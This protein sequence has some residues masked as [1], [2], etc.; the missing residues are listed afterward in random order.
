MKNFSVL[1][2]QLILTYYFIR[3]ETIFAEFKHS[4]IP[5]PGWTLPPQ[6]YK[7]FI[8]FEKLGCLTNADFNELLE[9]PYN[10]P[11]L[12]SVSD[13]ISTG[14]NIF[15]PTILLSISTF[16]VELIFVMIFFLRSF[17]I[18]S[19]SCPSSNGEFISMNQFSQP[20]GA[21]SFTIFDVEH[22]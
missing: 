20:A 11:N 19:Q 8:F 14:V 21:S 7:L 15:S 12:E 22:I 2:H 16:K 9:L 10:D 4:G 13:S 1:F 17:F 18:F 6:K 3:S 5:P